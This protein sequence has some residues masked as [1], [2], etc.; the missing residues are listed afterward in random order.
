MMRSQS[1]SMESLY[2]VGMEIF[3]VWYKKIAIF[4]CNLRNLCDLDII[5][6]RVSMLNPGINK[7][8]YMNMNMKYS[9]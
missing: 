8:T 2:F 6:M 3:V 7:G 5:V 1:N 9:T 4:L